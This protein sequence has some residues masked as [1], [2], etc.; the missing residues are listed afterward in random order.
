MK[1][2]SQKRVVPCIRRAAIL[3]R[4]SF[5]LMREIVRCESGFNP[6]ARNPASTATGLAQF[7]DTTWATTRYARYSRTS[8][9]WN[10]LALAQLLRQDGPRHWYSSRPCWG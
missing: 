10:S 5:P 7:L 8:A 2:C 3:Y 4:Q 6:W 1:Q 9:K